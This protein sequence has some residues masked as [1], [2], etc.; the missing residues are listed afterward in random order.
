MYIK[1]DYIIGMLHILLCIILW[2]Y[3]KCYNN[4]INLIIKSIIILLTDFIFFMRATGTEYLH[5]INYFFTT[6]LPL[7]Y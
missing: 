5:I 4:K 7:K 2:H 6:Q 3:A 1:V